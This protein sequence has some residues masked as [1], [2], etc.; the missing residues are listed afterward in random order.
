MNIDELP[1]VPHTNHEMTIMD[2]SS[3]EIKNV[4]GVSWLK[5]QRIDFKALRP[6]AM[7][8]G[9]LYVYQKRP[10]KC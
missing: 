5:N 2:A 3:V 1:P 10:T 9:K 6:A 4:R 8:K 7:I